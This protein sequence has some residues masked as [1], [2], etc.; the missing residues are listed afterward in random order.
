[1]GEHLTIGEICSRSVIIAFRQSS[2]SDAARLI[3]E[4]HFDSLGV[5]D[6]MR[7]AVG[8][9]SE[10][11]IMTA[12][13]VLKFDPHNTNM[14]VNQTCTK[15]RSCRLPSRYKGVKS[16]TEHFREGK[17][18]RQYIPLIFLLALLTGCA[19]VT[20]SI[21]QEN[22][23][24]IRSAR[25]ITV[26]V[27]IKDEIFGTRLSG[28]FMKPTEEFQT[29]WKSNDIIGKT[30]AS[31]MTSMGRKVELVPMDRLQFSGTIEFSSIGDAFSGLSRELS[32]KNPKSDADIHLIMLHVPVDAV[33]RPITG[34]QARMV[35][36]GL[37]GLMWELGTTYK[38]SFVVRVNSDINAIAWGKAQCIVVYALAAVDAHSHKVVQQLY[39]R[40]V[41]HPLPD[42]FWIS[43]FQSLTPK[44]KDILHSSC[45]GGLT[46]SVKE[47]LRKMGLR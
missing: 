1:M 32:Q 43:D 20:S 29:D 24:E 26:L 21:S 5:V 7:M 8:I 37:I 11:D 39:P 15:G 28:L 18:M 16:T 36:Q 30:I 9:L 3:R 35:G 40:W 34:A 19:S 4:N 46:M 42:D 10:R 12:V 31:N 6:G 17:H 41:D 27:D 44:D 38:Q 13:V 47:D 25:S 22:L 33:P 23:A 2:S 14:A 45:L